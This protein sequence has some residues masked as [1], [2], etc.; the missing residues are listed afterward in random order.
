MDDGLL[1]DGVDVSCD[2]LPVNK[3]IELA[4]HHPSNPAQTHLSLSNLTQPGACGT[5][6][7]PVGK[8][9]V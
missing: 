6:D 7:L 4:S 5:L 2:D 3:K 9:A 1:L 8:V